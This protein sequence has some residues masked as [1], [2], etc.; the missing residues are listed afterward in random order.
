MY[1]KFWESHHTPRNLLEVR[2]TYTCSGF[3][4]SGIIIDN[5]NLKLFSDCTV[6][7]HRGRPIALWGINSFMLSTVCNVSTN[8]FFLVIFVNCSA[9]TVNPCV[10]LCCPCRS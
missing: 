9:R 3:T 4:T 1:S 10:V 7:L 2:M 8:E 6:V 5:N